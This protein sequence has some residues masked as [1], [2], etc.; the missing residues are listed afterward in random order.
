M[1]DWMAGI[2]H[3]TMNEKVR[4]EYCRRTRLFLKSELNGANKIE[5]VNTL[6]VPVITYSFNMINWRVSKIKILTRKPENF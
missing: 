1:K 3:A 4:K 5:T 2:Q 6:I